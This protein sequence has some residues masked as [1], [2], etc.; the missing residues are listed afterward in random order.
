MLNEIYKKKNKQNNSDK[1]IYLVLHLMSIYKNR[2]YLLNH[3]LI[4]YYIMVWGAA[5]RGLGGR[6]R[7]VKRLC[8][9]PGNW[10]FI[11]GT[12]NAAIILSTVQ[13]SVNDQ[14]KAESFYWNQDAIME[15]R[16]RKF[17]SYH[18]H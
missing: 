4:Y 12:T 16:M 17:G 14:N 1:H 2:I 18:P 5:Y 3:T 8:T 6:L 15:E 11:V 9:L 7:L 13:Y 10:P